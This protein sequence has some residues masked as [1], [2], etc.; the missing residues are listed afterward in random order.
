MFKLLKRIIY[1]LYIKYQN[2]KS[3]SLKVFLWSIEHQEEWE[4]ICGINQ[5]KIDKEEF[6]NLM[7]M[8]VKAKFREIIIVLATIHY[9]AIKDDVLEMTEKLSSK[10]KEELKRRENEK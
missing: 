1:K 9:Y 8:L 2:K 10:I 6:N 7:Q 4:T 5:K 3:R